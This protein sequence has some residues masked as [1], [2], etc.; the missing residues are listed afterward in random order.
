MTL[1]TILIAI[2]AAVTVAI[3]YELRD[4]IRDARDRPEEDEVFD[5]QD[6]FHMA[7]QRRIDRDR[8]MQ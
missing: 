7:M 4:A 6:D 1:S 2:G 3:A 5:T 8:R